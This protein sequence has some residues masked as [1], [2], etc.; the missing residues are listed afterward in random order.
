[1]GVFVIRTSMYNTNGR[2]YI[3][4]ECKVQPYLERNC[5]VHRYR[6]NVRYSIIQSHTIFGPSNRHNSEAL[7]LSRKAYTR[8]CCKGK[9][10]G[11]DLEI[12]DIFSPEGNALFPLD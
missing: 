1:M 2:K 7:S 5:Y 10:T 3:G 6:I 9:A 4:I 8:A 12:M 11:R